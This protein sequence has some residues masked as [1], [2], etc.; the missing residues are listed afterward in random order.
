M[1]E[2]NGKF[3]VRCQSKSGLLY[4]AYSLNPILNNV[5][6]NKYIFISDSTKIS[7]ICNVKD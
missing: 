7:F 6:S 3:S 5:S 2:R 1:T 4:C